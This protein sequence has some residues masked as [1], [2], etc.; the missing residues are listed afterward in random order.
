MTRLRIGELLLDEGRVGPAD[1][2]AALAIQASIGGL[3]GGVLVRLGS[4]SEAVLL[5]A[6]S[7]QLGLEVQTLEALPPPPRIGAFQ[8]ETGVRPEWWAERQ[9][10]AWREPDGEVGD[11]VICAAVNPLDPV[12]RDVVEQ[13]A[14]GTAV[15]RLAPRSVAAVAL[16]DVGGTPSPAS[17]ADPARLRELAEETPV[18]DFV[19]G[20][21]AEALQR[22]ASDIHFEPFED[23]FQVRLRIDGILQTI[24]TGQR[25][26][27]DAVCSRVKLL[28]GMDIGERRLPQ[29]GRQAIRVSGQDVDLRVSSLP[30]SWGESLVLRLLGKSGRLPELSELG[31]DASQARLLTEQVRQPN[32]VV[33]VTGPT[34]SGKTTTIY[35]LLAGLND[36]QRKIVTVEDPVEF[37]LPG[38]IQTPVRSDIGLTFAAGLRAI[39]RQDPDI[40][41]VGEIRDPETA[42]IAVQAALTGHM[43]ISTIHTNSALGAVTRL[44]D[45]GVDDYI[46]GDVLRASVGQRL[47]RRLCD[48]CSR[49]A[50]PDQVAA[51]ERAC[52][53][54]GGGAPGGRA[55][56]WREPTGCPRCAGTGH[57]GRIGLFEV[58]SFSTDLLSAVRRAGQPDVLGS[59]ARHLGAAGLLADGL[60]KARAALTSVGE[61]YRVAGPTANETAPARALRGSARGEP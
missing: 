16:R 36:G 39:L 14:A 44:L 42:R 24:R 49:P 19:N 8:R 34:G 17:P 32:G 55:P 29:D 9:A 25:G 11:A 10:V 31:L 37:D 15:Y 22:R 4:L 27:F 45:L 20:V 54:H 59:L 18:I 26:G 21:F 35:R 28:S 2:E 5:D 58:V 48:A 52:V 40:I 6:L 12:L 23:S 46:L 61:V 51:Y 53:D 57:L 56:N 3:L 47:A 60:A 50:D 41:L 33:L 7:R 1:L 38:V 43:V 30:G 13:A